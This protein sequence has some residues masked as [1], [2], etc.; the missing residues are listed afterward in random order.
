LSQGLDPDDPL[1]K[2]LQMA[3]EAVPRGAAAE[4][5]ARHGVVGSTMEEIAAIAHG[6][7]DEYED[8]VCQPV[9]F[10]GPAPPSPR[11]TALSEDSDSDDE[12]G[13]TPSGGGAGLPPGESN[14]YSDAQLDAALAA[15]AARNNTPSRFGIT[16]DEDEESAA[17]RSAE[18]LDFVSS[19]LQDDTMNTTGVFSRSGDD[20]HDFRDLPDQGGF[21]SPEERSPRAA[22]A[23]PVSES[24]AVV[25]TVPGA[26]SSSGTAEEEMKASL[27]ATTRAMDRVTAAASAA[28][29]NLHAASLLA[30]A[31]TGMPGRVE[32]PELKPL[33]AILGALGKQVEALDAAAAAAARAAAE[34][35]AGSFTSSDIISQAE[36]SLEGRTPGLGFEYDETVSTE[37]GDTSAMYAAASAAALNSAP[38]TEASAHAATPGGGADGTPGG[39]ATATTPQSAGGSDYKIEPQRDASAAVV[40]SA[41]PAGIG[42]HQRRNFL[43]TEP[44]IASIAAKIAA[45]AYAQNPGEAPETVAK[46]VAAAMT[47]ALEAQKATRSPNARVDA[48]GSPALWDESDGNVDSSWARALGALDNEWAKSVV[49][50]APVPKTTS[51]PRYADTGYDD[52]EEEEEDRVSEEEERASVSTLAPPVRVPLDASDPSSTRP[53]GVRVG[54]GGWGGLDRS[55]DTEMS[56]S[57][58]GR[59]LAALANASF[60]V[61]TDEEND[62]FISDSDVEGSNAWEDFKTTVFTPTRAKRAPAP[63][64]TAKAKPAKSKKGKP[65]AA[66]AFKARVQRLAAKEQDKAK[67]SEP[68]SPEDEAAAAEERMRKRKEAAALRKKAA[69]FDR[70]NRE[71]LQKLQT[72]R[73]K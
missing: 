16:E 47:E 22:G 33:D 24:T 65:P 13:Y 50:I 12:D 19:A 1:L 8:P 67:V 10:Q 35:S 14:F 2:V 68:V 29:Y 48:P 27:A 42:Q 21:G 55:A 58:D 39:A 49:D 4:R 62:M 18:E 31:D 25:S 7:D 44:E 38:P 40:H 61:P 64:T 71:H 66:P 20:E 32:I 36:A 73:K 45:A 9:P 52:D 5:L 17:R 23:G 72:L 30:S 63:Q 59:S 56:L 15:V 69:A 34:P 6:G 41:T 46:R 28:E 54:G 43:S 26:S 53:E 37:M 51:P 11:V 60:D 3:K 57:L 70:R